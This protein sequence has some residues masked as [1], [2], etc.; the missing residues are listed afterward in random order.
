VLNAT[1]IAVADELAATADL[2]RRKDGGEPVVLVRGAGRQV[3]TDDGPGASALI[4]S[5][6]QDL[7]R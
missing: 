1:L 4:R 5:E 3:T 7:F 6:Q 2:A